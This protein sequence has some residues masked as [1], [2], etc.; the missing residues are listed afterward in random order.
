MKAS[1]SR[2]H[3]GL[4]IL[5]LL[6]SA[7]QALA[8]TPADGALQQIRA[9]GELRV[10]L[11]AG[12]MPFEMRDKR[13]GIIGFVIGVLPGAGGT[14]AS[15][16]SYTTEKRLS[17]HPEE[18]G[19]GAIEGVAAPEAANNAGATAAMV[20][21]LTLGI[22]GSATTAIMLGG[23]M[24]WGLRPGP[25]LFEK[26]P[27]FVWGLIAS[28]YIANIL[29]LILSTAFIPLFVALSSSSP[30]WRG[31]ET[32]LRSYRFAAY[33]ELPRTGLP[34][35]FRGDGE[36]QLYLD[37]LLT[38]GALARAER[39]AVH[40]PRAH[41]AVRRRDHELVRDPAAPD[42]QG[43][44]L[45]RDDG[46]RAAGRGSRWHLVRAAARRRPV[47]DLGARGVPRPHL[48]PGRRRPG[49]ACHPLGARPRRP[50]PRRGP[51]A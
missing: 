12:Y 26:N 23:L 39:P 34:P 18:F 38:S 51:R 15:I 25:M 46:A 29:L 14:I 5:L 36:Y 32:G 24:M 8:Q 35:I 3:Q 2:W 42:A 45:R 22:P 33:D 30:F 43:D 20:P 37:A 40:R 48:G 17:K 47:P 28:Q 7:C 44:A 6:A 21:M 4:L 9:R 11:E 1:T 13:G 16:M 27:Q 19:K 50:R 41:P 49:R 31:E 10:G